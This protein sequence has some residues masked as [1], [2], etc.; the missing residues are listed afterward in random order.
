MLSKGVA[1]RPLSLI[2]R[3]DGD[4]MEAYTDTTARGEE[5][6]AVF[7]FRE[8]AEMY[9][10]LCLG[11]LGHDLKILETSNE[12]LTSILSGPCREVKAIVLDPLPEACCGALNGLLSVRRE[13]F[14]VAL[15]DK[16]SPMPSR[17][18]GARVGGLGSGLIPTVS[19]VTS[20]SGRYS[21][22]LMGI[23]LASCSE[24]PISSITDLSTDI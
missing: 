13:K 8:E 21:L 10:H 12:E 1:G 11:M 18:T 22:D 6:L 2:V 23:Y 3:S 14:V 20:H 24:E 9:L 7:S 4:W 19:T 15:L 5:V 17:G 16:G